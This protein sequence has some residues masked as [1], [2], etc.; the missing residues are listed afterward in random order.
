MWLCI[1]V[2]VFVPDTSPLKHAHTQSLWLCQLL[3]T[4]VYTNAYIELMPSVLVHE[5]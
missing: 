4:Y 5:L 2:H 3:C 1:Y